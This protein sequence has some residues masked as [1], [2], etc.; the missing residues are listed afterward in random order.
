MFL[1]LPED[2]QEE[3]HTMKGFFKNVNDSQGACCIGGNGHY[4]LE[5][6]NGK[7]II[8]KN[9]GKTLSIPVL[10]IENDGS[11]NLTIELSEKVVSL[12]DRL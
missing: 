10:R 4:R 6:E 5:F 8:K 1:E 7:L 12:E 3:F 9:N 2:V 11:E